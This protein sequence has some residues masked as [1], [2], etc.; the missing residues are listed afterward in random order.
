MSTSPDT[1]DLVNL[2]DL[3]L[4]EI[5]QLKMD[6]PPATPAIP[7]YVIV[8]YQFKS[9]YRKDYVLVF[10]RNALRGMDYI[11]GLPICLKKCAVM[12]NLSVSSL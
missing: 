9:T 4:E 7:P 2:V 3:I 8:Y 12:I 1:A 11:V 5:R 6:R 10:S